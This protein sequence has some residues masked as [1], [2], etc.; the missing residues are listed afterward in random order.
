MYPAPNSP[1]PDAPRNI[2][3]IGGGISGMGAAFALS[4]KHHV[5]L[6][7]SRSRLGG[8]AR[9]LYAGPGHDIPVDTG[10]MVFNRKNYPNLI[11][12]FAQLG[13]ADRPTNMTFAVSLDNGRFEYGLQDLRRILGDPR[14]A[15]NPTF[16]RMIRDIMKFNAK[17]TDYLDRPECSLAQALEE[18]NMSD[19]FTYRYLFPLAGAIWSTSADDMLRFPAATLVRFFANHGL[20]SA[21][22]GPDWYTPVGGSISYV[23]RL[24]SRLKQAGA[25]IR[26]NTKVVHIARNLDGVLVQ[27]EGMEPQEFDAVVMAC[28]T[29][30]ALEILT[31]ATALEQEVLRAIRYRSNEVILHTDTS[32]MPKRRACWSSWVYKGRLNDPANNSFTYWMNMLQGISMQTPLFVTL[33]PREPI[34]DEHV[35]DTT[36]LAHPQYDIAAIR[37]Q[38]KL[39]QMQGT[40]HTWYCGA[41]TGYGFHEDGLASGYAVA[42]Q[43]SHTPLR[44]QAAQ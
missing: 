41:W 36:R 44:L 16:W 2:A 32:Q 19:A 24:Q 3:I 15:I 43:I 18:M 7:E 30:Q 25:E 22:G 29:N 14:N 42:E 9:T 34:A 17:A 10:F 6:F 39:P 4:D 23:K 20:L 40:N 13:I 35:Y 31:D 12:L 28:H 11:N 1:I 21:S 8:H 38:E 37:A 27:A 5:T 33:N 26:L